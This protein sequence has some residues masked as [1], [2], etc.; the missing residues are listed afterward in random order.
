MPNDK[1][2]ENLAA[3]DGFLE[4]LLDLETHE[5]F[6][7]YQE[8]ISAQIERAQKELES[9]NVDF[10]HTSI[11]RGG[12]AALRMCQ[13]GLQTMIYERRQDIKDREGG[14]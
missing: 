12:I 10:T 7:L 9:V 3:D 14:K 8:W 2:L 1:E 5:G 13:A 6:R 11:N 4:H